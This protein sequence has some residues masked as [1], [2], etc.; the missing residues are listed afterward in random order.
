MKKFLILSIAAFL[1]AALLSYTLKPAEPEILTPEC[2]VSC[3]NSDVR[4]E[5][6]KDATTTAFAKLH[7]SPLPFEFKGEGKMIKFK[8][9]DGNEGGAYFIKAKK[10]T[11]NYLFVIQEWWGLNDYIKQESET[12]YNELGNVN[13]IALDLYDGKVASV[14]DSAMA[15]MRSVKNERLE[16]IVKGAIAYAGSNANIYS[17]GWCFGG[18]WSLQTAL[19]AGPQAKG[20]VMYYGRPEKDLAKLKSLNTDVLGFFANNDKGIPPTAVDEF[21]KNM[22]EAGKKLTVYRYDAGHGFA[23]PSNP[24]YDKTAS[25][26]SHKKALEYFRE[27][28]K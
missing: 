27:R 13:V 26:D 11:N 12:F 14:P 10:K 23:N 6:R 3:F 2:Y 8:T 4:E 18:M 1:S 22:Q 28:T 9:A 17:V 16:A 21:Q 15:I 7:L 25:E 19:L 20:C 5:F 24:I